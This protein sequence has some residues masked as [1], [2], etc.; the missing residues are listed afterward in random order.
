MVNKIRDFPFARPVFNPKLGLRGAS[1]T[2]GRSRSA[3]EWPPACIEWRHQSSG[4]QKV[5]ARALGCKK[6]S[7]GRRASAIGRAAH[8]RTPCSW[9]SRG[10]RTSWPADLGKRDGRTDGQLFTLTVA[11]NSAHALPLRAIQLAG[12]LCADASSG[13]DPLMESCVLRGPDG[14]QAGLKTPADWRR[15]FARPLEW[16]SK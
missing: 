13:R 15:M 16:A 1:V 14:C 10:G 7:T 9:A 6:Q 4:R 2:S 12:Q 5:V 11:I 8:A 3:S